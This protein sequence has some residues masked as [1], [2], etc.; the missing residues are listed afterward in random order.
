MTPTDDNA[1]ARLLADY[2]RARGYADTILDIPNRSIT[3]E[4]ITVL[5]EWL[6]DLEAR[7]PGDE[8]RGRDLA[9]LSICRALGTK[10][11]R[12]SAAIPALISQFDHAKNINAH[13]RAAAGIAL[14][15]IPADNE[16]FDQLAAIAADREFGKSR[17]MVVAWLGKSR[18]PDAA[19]VAMTQLNDESVQGNALDALARMR[20]QG[21]R[22]QIEP[23]LNA[24]QAWH[25]RLAERIFR[26]DQS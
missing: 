2:H 14:Y 4:I 21:V 12:K 3:P 26:Y 8:T 22:E 19:A 25:R 24:K 17:A 18:H 11:S 5:P 23:F 13:T 16:Y 1:A 10:E 6:T 15:D 7:W 9:R 20:A